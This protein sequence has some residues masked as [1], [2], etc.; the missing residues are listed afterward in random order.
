MAYEATVYNVMIA[1][2]SDV[3]EEREIAREVV[4]EWNDANAE[5]DGMVLLPLA[6]ETHCAPV[7]GGSAQSVINSQILGP[8]D[9][10][11]ALFWTRLGT[12]TENAESGT[13]AEIRA[14]VDHGKPA[15]IYFS[16]T[17]VPPDEMDGEQYNRLKSFKGWCEQQGLIEKYDSSDDFRGKFRR[18]LD[19]LT[20]KH[21]LFVDRKKREA[22]NAGASGN[23]Q[24]ALSP[25]AR[26]LLEAAARSD[27]RVLSLAMKSG[28]VV[29]ADER[30]FAVPRN[31][32]TIAI[33]EGAIEELKGQRCLQ[34]IGTK[35][36][37]FKV[38]RTGFERADTFAA[39][40]AQ[41]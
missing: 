11:V 27:G 1:S 41:S 30:D 34:E 6:W 37:I 23:S 32:R 3:V 40:S 13:A 31:P 39:R 17:P 26:S 18:Q 12:P 10:L 16:A 19:I 25:E 9:L 36:E 24:P 7:T 20:K 35:G 15:M 4:L 2:P 8:S 28:K 5:S 29:Q 21:P 38:T 14:H 22:E 33:W